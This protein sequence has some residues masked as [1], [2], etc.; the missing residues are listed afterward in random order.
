M[1]ELSIALSLID[2]ASAEARRHPGR[3]R[4]VHMRLGA[5]SGVVARALVS[6]FEL[7]REGTILEE[8]QLLIEEAPLVVLCP[9]CGGERPAESLQSLRCRECG[10]PAA[11]V[12]GGQEVELV[13]L[14]VEA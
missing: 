7:A 14:E 4:V 1:H 11:R 9:S 6:A 10:T 2:I 3:V 5:F 13:A 8:S 12:V